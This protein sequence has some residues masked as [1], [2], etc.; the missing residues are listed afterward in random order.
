MKLFDLRKKL[1]D[2]FAQLDIDIVDVDFIVAHILG[3]PVTLLPLIDDVDDDVCL[4]IQTKINMRTS[5]MPVDR[6]FGNKY[7]YGLEFYI[8]DNVLSPRQDSEV[9]VDTALKYINDNH[10]HDVLDM[11]TGSGC[12]AIAVKRNAPVDVTAV[13]VSKKAL[14]VA[15]KNADKHGEDIKFIQSNMFEKLDGKFDIIISNPPYI[16]RDEIKTLDREVIDHDP[17]IAL[18]GGESGLKFY[19]IIHDNLRKYLNDDGV[20]VIEI[21]ED[22]RM[23]IEALFNDFELLEC[24]KDLS[25]HDRVMVFKK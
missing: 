24:V 4:E 16:A 7:F 10:Y 1:K 23:L 18:D 5:G 22:Q 21:G 6:I 2:E 8:D 9:L 3:V 20:L 25:G 15:K 12:L 19:N 11:C 13:D 17:L 14:I